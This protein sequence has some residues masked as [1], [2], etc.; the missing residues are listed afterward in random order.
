[1]IPQPSSWTAFSSTTRLR[2]ALILPPLQVSPYIRQSRCY[3]IAPLGG[4][5][6][7]AVPA[8]FTHLRAIHPALAFE[9]RCKRLVRPDWHSRQWYQ[10]NLH[11]RPWP[12][13]VP[14]A[15]VACPQRLHISS[16][17]SASRTTSVADNREKVS[18]DMTLPAI[19]EGL[20]EEWPQRQCWDI[21]H[22]LQQH[23]DTDFVV[24]A[25]SVEDT[26]DD[27]RGSEYT[28]GDTAV[29]MTIR[30]YCEYAA[31][32]RDDCPLYIFD[33]T[34]LE[35][36]GP[37]VDAY[38][39]PGCFVED[40]MSVLGE[41][42]P[43]YRWMLIGA[44]R[45]GTALHVDPLETCAWNTLVSGRKRWVLFPPSPEPPQLEPRPHAREC[46]RDYIRRE[47]LGDP[48][49]DTADSA[50]HWMQ[51]CY[52]L[53]SPAFGSCFDFIQLPGETVYVPNGW[54]HNV[55]NLEFSVAVTE[56][57]VGRNNLEASHAAVHRDN[58]D[59]AT[60]WLDAM[61]GDSVAS[62]CSDAIL[63]MKKRAIE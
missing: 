24:G 1:M 44:E 14:H 27:S 48:D 5:H 11:C 39:S 23:S 7:D 9:E 30:A 4:L 26:G 25:T 29:T 59:L 61:E 62:P 54:W 13:P 3:G 43:P 56:N 47:G 33:D 35:R 10:D 21:D 57:F 41:D 32:Q 31:R 37:L 45:A 28:E 40:F 36:G 49:A 52:P 55:V 16:I 8:P 63:A 38:A 42:R 17:S 60:R 6:L 15:T 46:S 19:L 58:P 53:L 34:F 50:V 51:Y 2:H 18:L 20:L 22:I 12:A